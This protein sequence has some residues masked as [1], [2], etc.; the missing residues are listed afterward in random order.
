MRA[1]A[2]DEPLTPT[3]FAPRACSDRGSMQMR[4]VAVDGRVVFIGR[5]SRRVFLLEYDAAKVDFVSKEVTRLKQE[6][7]ESLVVDVAAQRQPDTRVYMVLG[8]GSIAVLVHE[9]NEDVSAL[10]PFT[11]QDARVERVAC[12]PGVEEDKVYIYIARGAFRC[13]EKFAMRSEA[14]GGILNKVMDSHVLFYSP[15]PA[16]SVPM[17]AH[18]EGQAVVVGATSRSAPRRHRSLPVSSPCRSPCRTL[19]GLP[20]TASLQTSKLAFAAKGGTSLSAAKRVGRISLVMSDVAWKGV[21]IGRDFSHMQSLP[22]TYRGRPL[23]PI[24]VVSEWDAIPSSWNGGWGADPRVCI[25]VASPYCCTLMGLALGEQIN[26]GED[27]PPP[28]EPG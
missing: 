16:T 12:L 13:I 5:G 15:T 20:Y 27:A 21:K 14:K 26:E 8:N 3:A 9:P 23:G 22:A 28:R 19:V 25:Q 6:M 11:F 1:S 2:F 17:P 4:A 7:C 24:E 10:V 18:L